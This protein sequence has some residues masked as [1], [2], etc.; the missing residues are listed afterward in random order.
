MANGRLL[1]LALLVLCDCY[2]LRLHS[3]GLIGSLCVPL[4]NFSYRYIFKSSIHFEFVLLNAWGSCLGALGSCHQYLDLKF[5]VLKV[6]LGHLPVAI[7]LV[8]LFLLRCIETR[9]YCARSCSVLSVAY[10]VATCKISHCVDLPFPFYSF[11]F[12]L[13]F[14]VRLIFLHMLTPSLWLEILILPG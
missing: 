12:F 5:F 1:F 6:F 11:K 13:R 7:C 10:C 14:G 9:A 3:A 4:G 2:H 8:L